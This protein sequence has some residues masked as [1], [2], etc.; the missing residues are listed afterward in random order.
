MKRF[1]LTLTLLLVPA[2]SAC[3]G[4]GGTTTTPGTGS[5][6]GTGTGPGSSSGTLTHAMLTSCPESNNSQDREVANCLKGSVVGKTLAGSVCTFT[7]G[8]NLS[9][10]YDSPSSKFSHTASSKAYFAYTYRKDANLLMWELDDYVG[11]RRI[12]IDFDYDLGTRKVEIN[13]KNGNVAS[14]CTATL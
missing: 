14:T 11:D 7:V 5:G 8:D 1:A 9:I 6:S 13:A 12:L 4:S 10:T 2:L 3:G